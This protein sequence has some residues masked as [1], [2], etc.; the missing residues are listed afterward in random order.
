MKASRNF[1][2]AASMLA[3]IQVQANMVSARPTVYDVD[4]IP[5]HD[6][7]IQISWKIPEWTSD[8]KPTGIYIFR[9]SKPIEDIR[10]MI[11]VA[12]VPV[13]TDTYTDM[14]G[15]FRE[16]FYAVL[17]TT[18]PSIETQYLVN[19]L[20]YYDQEIDALPADE[21]DLI[22]PGIN[23]TTVGSRIRGT[24]HTAENLEAM[25]KN[26]IAESENEKLYSGGVLREKPL[27][28][29]EFPGSLPKAVPSDSETASYASRVLDGKK[30]SVPVKVREIYIFPE[31]RSTKKESVPLRRFMEMD[32]ARAEKD[33]KSFISK[34]KPES[35]EC[36]RARFY[37]AECMYFTG[38]FAG[39]TKEFALLQDVFPKLCQE[40]ARSSLDLME[41]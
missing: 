38:D 35:S 25:Q 16:Y 2:V 12:T 6:D 4:A 7:S 18:N 33:L 32:F 24:V 31:D 13:S 3:L 17:V 20:Y 9:D 27:P 26:R 1:K 34:K 5:L 29:M 22:L 41:K 39:A 28:Y 10:G 15:D 19:G 30:V 23:C 40:W 37:L 8:E 11:P 14:P 21:K 36:L